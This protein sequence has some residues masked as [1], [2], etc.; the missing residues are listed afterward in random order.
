MKFLKAAS[1]AAAICFAGN[2]SAWTLI[3]AHDANG[4]ATAGSLQA[5]RAAVNAGAS[6]KILSMPPGVHN[7]SVLCSQVSVRPDPS[8]SVAC[9]GADMALIVD[10]TPGANFGVPPTP[11]HSSNFAINTLGQYA[12][13]KVQISNGAIVSRVTFN[14]PAQWFV[15]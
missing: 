5:L 10:L 1:L 11:I 3:Y 2:A 4:T 14:Y 7:W 12:E 15:E 9:V 6:V 13:T 8:Q